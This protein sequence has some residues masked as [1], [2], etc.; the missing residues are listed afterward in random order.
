M[1][2]SE[3]SP[4]NQL[5]PRNQEGHPQTVAVFRAL[6]EGFD[7]T[8]TPEHQRHWESMLTV[9][10]VVD[11]YVDT[12]KPD[13]ILNEHDRLMAG[14]PIPG[15]NEASAR[16]FGD[17]VAG[18]TPERQTAISNGLLQLN[19]YGIEMRSARG[20]TKFLR[21]RTEE[22]ELF[23]RFM[24]L[25]N[26][27][28]LPAIEQF[29]A[30]LPHFAR[31]GYLIDSFGDLTDDYCDGIIALR[32]TMTRRLKLGKAALMETKQAITDLPPRTLA[33]L[34]LAS[35]SKIARNGLKKK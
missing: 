12:Q 30:W 6:A 34:A 14:L 25:D 3:S 13:S 19:E 9:A 27:D 18:V 24:Q 1:Q 26:P 21:L 5:S 7:V 8:V 16:V 2:N 20:Y 32:P 15:I 11:S 23:G 33:F 35:L 22:A 31:A 29:N 28:Q 17:I 4:F 10:R